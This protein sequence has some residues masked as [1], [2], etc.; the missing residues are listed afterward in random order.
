MPTHPTYA[1]EAVHTHRDGRTYQ[2]K[3]EGKL[4]THHEAVRSNPTTRLG[5]GGY[6]ARLFVGL[7]VGQKQTWSEKDVVDL[8]WKTRKKQ[9]RSADA[10][11]LTQKGIYEDRSG[12]RVVEPSVQ[13]IIID[14][15]RAPKKQ[16]VEEMSNL[17]E[18][19]VEKLKQ[20]TVILEIQR[21]GVTTDVYSIT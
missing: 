8:V 10:S 5:G 15:S 6:S 16:F 13:V 21:R 9:G 19:L 20:E 18:V 4:T 1:G 14:F 11:I 17:S 7:N 3:P 12:E 2:F